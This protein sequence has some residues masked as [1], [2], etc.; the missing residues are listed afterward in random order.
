M[1]HH[2]QIEPELIGAHSSRAHAVGE[3]YKLFFD[4]VLH[5]ATGTIQ[6]FIQLL[7]SPSFRSDRGHNKTRIRFAV[8]VL[9]LDH[10]PTTAAPGS[11]HGFVFKLLKDSCRLL[12]LRPLLARL[13]Q[14]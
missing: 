3:Q 5:V 7:S 10:D 11:A 8:D 12:G 14:S 9:S 13:S 4:A 1:S 2:G 6:I